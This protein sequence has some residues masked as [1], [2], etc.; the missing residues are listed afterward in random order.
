M[1]ERNEMRLMSWTHHRGSK[2]E[3]YVD[4]VTKYQVHTT[5]Q[6]VQEVDIL[7]KY[8]EHISLAST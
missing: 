1:C 7:T 5:Q 3:Q 4:I 6:Q 2:Q 8:Q